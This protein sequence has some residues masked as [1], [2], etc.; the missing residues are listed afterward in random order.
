MTWRG[1][2]RRRTPVAGE[3]KQGSGLALS[4]A[5][6]PRQPGDKGF[7]VSHQ[8]SGLPQLRPFFGKLGQGLGGPQAAHPA[9]LDFGDEAGKLLV[10]LGGTA[11]CLRACRDSGF[12]GNLI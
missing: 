1:Q 10:A 5:E 11:T 7:A 3:M 2:A 12:P 9:H 4:T 8:D 6:S